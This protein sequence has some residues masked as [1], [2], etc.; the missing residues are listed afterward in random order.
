MKIKTHLFEPGFCMVRNEFMID[1][2]DIISLSSHVTLMNTYMPALLYWKWDKLCTWF[3]CKHAR[4]TLLNEVFFPSF[5]K[6]KLILFY[7]YVYIT[8]IKSVKNINTYH[9]QKAIIERKNIYIILILKA[10]CHIQCL[11]IP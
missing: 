1:I 6:W 4:Q 3:N 11:K 5:C 10:S 8:I 9:L 7:L 2:N